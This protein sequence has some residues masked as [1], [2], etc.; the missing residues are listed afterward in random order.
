MYNIYIRYLG[1]YKIFVKVKYFVIKK[2]KEN[3]KISK[4]LQLSA[5]KNIKNLVM[6]PQL[7][8]SLKLV[9]RLEVM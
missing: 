3:I 5:T 6:V 4:L 2:F 1:T 8:D 9:K 7:S